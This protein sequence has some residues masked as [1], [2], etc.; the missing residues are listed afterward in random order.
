MTGLKPEP[1]PSGHP[2]VVIVDDQ[3][4]MRAALR[5]IIEADEMLVLGEAGDGDAA[6]RLAATLR[7]DVVVMDVRMPG[8]NGI[9]ATEMLA[10]DQPAVAVLVLTTFDDD[11]T[12]FGALRAGARGF[13]LKNAAPEELQQAV[14]RVAV[15][16]AVLDD[17]VTARVMRRFVEPLPTAVASPTGAAAEHSDVGRLTE[18]ERDVLWLLAEGLANAEIAQTLGIGEA[19]AKSHVSS[20]ILKLGVRDRV[21]AVIRAYETGFTQRP[22]SIQRHTRHDQLGRPSNGGAD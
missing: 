20:V 4:M 10:R 7:P 11:A 14:R 12:L 2:T 8:R 15:G 16:D 18:R 6:I 17:S 13:L 21:Q 22:R 1:D 19:T 9:S 5:T 3:P